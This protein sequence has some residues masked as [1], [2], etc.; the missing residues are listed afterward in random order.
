VMGS[1]SLRLQ[2]IGDSTHLKTISPRK[3]FRLSMKKPSRAVTVRFG[4][5]FRYPMGSRTYGGPLSVT[6][7][8]VERPQIQAGIVIMAKRQ[9]IIVKRCT[10]MCVWSGSGGRFRVLEAR[11]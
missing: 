10:L 8:T 4:W 5:E 3:P 9:P 6:I 7:I 2:F 1:W 11:R